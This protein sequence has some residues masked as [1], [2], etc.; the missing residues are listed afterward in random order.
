MS[1]AEIRLLQLPLELIPPLIVR[2]VACSQHVTARCPCYDLLPKALERGHVL[3]TFVLAASST[4]RLNP[5]SYPASMTFSALVD[6]SIEHLQQPQC[7]SVACN[8]C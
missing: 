8:S 2:V 5:S 6:L 7:W 3:G 1:R 4:K